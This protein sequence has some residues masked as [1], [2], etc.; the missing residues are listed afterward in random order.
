VCGGR[1]YRRRMHPERG[2]ATTEWTGLVLLIALAMAALATLVPRVDGRSLGGAV[3]HAITCSARGGCAAERAPPRPVDRAPRRPSRPAVT[4]TRAAAA[5]QALR[6][7]REVAKKA[8]IVCLGYRRYL[9]ERDHP[10]APTEAMPLD[11][12]LGIANECLNP[13]GF[14]LEG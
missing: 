6:G 4:A 11:E 14:F 5:F 2:Q 8:W 13:L 12:A 9:Y 3:A 7:V 10:R 1:S